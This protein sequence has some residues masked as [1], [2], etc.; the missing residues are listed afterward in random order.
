M[1]VALL[2]SAISI[3]GSDEEE[4]E[5]K[6]RDFSVLSLHYLKSHTDI[7]P[8]L[9]IKAI[10]F[11]SES[12]N[13]HATDFY[14]GYKIGV[15]EYKIYDFDLKTQL[16]EFSGSWGWTYGE[17][18][19]Y[20]SVIWERKRTTY[21]TTRL[22]SEESEDVKEVEKKVDFG[23]GWLVNKGDQVFRVGAK[24]IKETSDGVLAHV[25][26][27]FRATRSFDLRIGYEREF[28]T[29]KAADGITLGW[30]VGF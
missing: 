3:F 15:A 2:I 12:F 27:I 24:G 4:P 6:D 14:S 11:S 1:L 22:R 30:V 29:D 20:A 7:D 28:E 26:V 8:D 19:P 25:D 13:F 21:K 17:H 5:K 16:L 9:D 10:G 18:T 23:I